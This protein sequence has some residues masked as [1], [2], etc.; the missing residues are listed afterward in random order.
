MLLVKVIGENDEYLLFHIR[1]MRIKFN[2]NLHLR[3]N[4]RRGLIK[5]K[6]YTIDC[7]YVV[8]VSDL[9]KI[10]KLP[11]PRKKLLDSDGSKLKLITVECEV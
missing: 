7:R 10:S 1:L 5:M 2:L 11:R 6:G 3:H 9:M 4:D 8:R